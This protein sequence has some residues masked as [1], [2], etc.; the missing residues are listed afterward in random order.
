MTTLE[1]FADEISNVLNL[2]DG[3]NEYPW[4]IAVQD[5]E[6]IIDGME[7]YHPRTNATK[8]LLKLLKNEAQFWIDTWTHKGEMI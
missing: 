5:M 2:C 4:K 7:H 8:L 3:G 6:D 1:Y